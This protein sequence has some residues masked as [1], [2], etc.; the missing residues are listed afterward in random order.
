MLKKIGIGFGI[1]AGLILVGGVVYFGFLSENP[2]KHKPVVSNDK[3]QPTGTSTAGAAKKPAEKIAKKDQTTAPAVTLMP[4]INRVLPDKEIEKIGVKIAQEKPRGIPARSECYRI[5][6]NIQEKAIKSINCV[7]GFIIFN[8]EEAMSG[9]EVMLA[10]NKYDGVDY[11]SLAD[12]K[13]SVEFKYAVIEGDL[14]GQTRKTTKIFALGMING[15]TASEYVIL[16][17]PDVLTSK[18]SEGI[19]TICLSPV[20]AG[21]GALDLARKVLEQECYLDKTS[22][23]L[24][25]PQIEV[26]QS[27]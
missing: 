10:I 27:K 17:C 1:L 12:E 9:V 26:S 22:L 2:Y 20:I 15:S 18:L 8:S 11:Y 21:I 13:G 19:R 4:K 5:V 25:A 6:K 16:E 3:S 23:Q 7:N 14:N 24:L